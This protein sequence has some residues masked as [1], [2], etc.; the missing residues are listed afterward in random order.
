MPRPLLPIQGSPVP[1]FCQLS[2]SNL[3][4]SSSGSLIRYSSARS[5]KPSGSLGLMNRLTAV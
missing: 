4:N 3:Q 1:L 5:S 2:A